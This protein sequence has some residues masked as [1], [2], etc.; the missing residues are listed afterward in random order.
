MLR[1]L[2]MKLS[3][4]GKRKP[5]SLFRHRAADFAHAVADADYRGL[6]RGI[7]VSPSPGVNDP[8]ALAANGDGKVLAEIA[9]KERGIRRHD[10]K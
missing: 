5:R 3:R 2:R 7:E 1:R 8:A 6:A 10:V 9:R 4:M